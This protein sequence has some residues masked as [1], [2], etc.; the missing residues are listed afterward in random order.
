M[1][2]SKAVSIS[3]DVLVSSV[4]PSALEDI[5]DAA[6]VRRLVAVW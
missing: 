2:R 1:V 3:G 6:W 5:L 4:L